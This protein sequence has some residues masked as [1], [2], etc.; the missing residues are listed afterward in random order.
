MCCLYVYDGDYY[1]VRCL[2]HQK[3]LGEPSPSL[4]TTSAYSLVVIR[5][6]DMIQ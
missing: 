3:G 4:K 1:G 6:V 5:C 2:W